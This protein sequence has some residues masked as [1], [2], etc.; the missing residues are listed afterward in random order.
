MEDERMVDIGLNRL[1]Q[2]PVPAE[3]ADL[4][5]RVLGTIQ[6]AG[7]RAHGGASS[8]LRLAAAGLALSMGI[9]A[10]AL[11]STDAYASAALSPLDGSS[12]LAPSTLLLNER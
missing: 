7:V 3:L 6:A 11:P 1:A 10:G 8:G 12:D 9:V 4:E 2:A 5:Q